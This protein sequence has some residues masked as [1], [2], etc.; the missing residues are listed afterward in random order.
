MDGAVDDAVVAA[1]VADAAGVVAGAVGD[2]VGVKMTAFGVSRPA[3]WGL[4]NGQHGSQLA[5]ATPDA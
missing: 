3:N 1:V 2:V 5:F 4:S